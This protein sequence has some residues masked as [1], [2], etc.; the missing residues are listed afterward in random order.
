MMSA[1][2]KKV[3]DQLPVNYNIKVDIRSL[4]PVDVLQIIKEFL[5]KDT[6]C[7]G[8]IS[9]FTLTDI[10]RNTF[11]FKISEDELKYLIKYEFQ[12][13][14][15]EKEDYYLDNLVK[16]LDLLKRE[17]TTLNEFNKSLKYSVFI[18][19]FVLIVIYLYI[20]YY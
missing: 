19:L 10:V 18:M 9:L 6:K 13:D 14:D 20:F 15:V 5:I 12:F 1:V 4:E 16:I 2:V 7:E 17:K 3:L 11:C 8:T